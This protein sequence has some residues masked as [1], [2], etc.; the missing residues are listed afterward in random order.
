M[1]RPIEKAAFS[2]S[3]D[4]ENLIIQL[5]GDFKD[6][7][8]KDK[9]KKFSLLYPLIG[10][11]YAKTKFLVYGRATNGWDFGD[12]GGWEISE[13]DKNISQIIADG[14]EMSKYNWEAGEVSKNSAFWAL[15][16]NILK[17]FYKIKDDKDLLK[18]FTWSNLMKIAPAEKGNP[19]VVQ[20]RNQLPKCKEIF[21]MEID[22][23]KPKNVLLITGLDWA[24]DFIKFLKL[25]P[26]KMKDGKLINGTYDYNGT[27]IVVCER[28]EGKNQEE[29]YSAVKRHLI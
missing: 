24:Y 15:V 18:Y 6:K 3:T 4:Y 2:S 16:K 27:K 23:L 22:I 10:E 13:I 14:K 5:L 20:W 9:G 19:T 17:I 21:K 1:G 8:H 11:N 25:D 7:H 26:E 29:F 28:P 12:M